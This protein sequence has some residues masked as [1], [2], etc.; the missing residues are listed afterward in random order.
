MNREPRRLTADKL[1][2]RPDLLTDVK[3]IGLGGS[4]G[5]VAR[6]GALYLASLEADTR[7]FLIDGD[8][9][10]PP[11]SS[12]MLCGGEGNKA[13]VVKDDL[14]RYFGNRR[15]SLEAIPQYVTPGTIGNLIR[16][17][18]IVLLAVD[19]HATRKLVS[20]FCGEQ[21]ENICLISGGNDGIGE[22]SQRR[23]TRG[24]AGN[25]QIYIRRDGEDVTPSLTRFH[26]EIENPAD[27]RPDESCVDMLESTPQ[28][29]FT[30]LMTAVSMLNTLWL[31]L[32][33][34]L[35]YPEIA[36]DIAEGLMRPIQ[37]PLPVREGDAAA[38]HRPSRG[39]HG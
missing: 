10:V 13:Y 18:D 39:A 4:G 12:R 22:D 24:T 37:L 20:D 23:D 3:L 2:L 28:I 11:N 1:V 36:F 33:G 27:T 9:F 31:Y 19:N 32:C 26:A 5:P 16:E 38:E 7:L 21:R 25:C 8:G 35:H 29:A 14:L 17:G 6:Y 15:L 34:A 30:N